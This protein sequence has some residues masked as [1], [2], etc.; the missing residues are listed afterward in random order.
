MN[1]PNNTYWITRDGRKLLIADMDL[2]HVRMCVNMMVRLLGYNYSSYKY[3]P[4]IRLCE[5]ITAYEL[6][7]VLVALTDPNL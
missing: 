6:D 1:T 4:K 5:L 7:N 2:Q 3:C